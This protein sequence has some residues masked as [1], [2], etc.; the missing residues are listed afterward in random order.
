MKELIYDEM[1]FSSVAESNDPYEGKLVAVFEKTP[2]HWDRLIKQALNKEF[3]E[4]HPSLVQELLNLPPPG[5][6]FMR[7]LIIETILI[8]KG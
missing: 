5:G 1:Y 4:E 8:L 3:Q 6:G 7:S 2:E